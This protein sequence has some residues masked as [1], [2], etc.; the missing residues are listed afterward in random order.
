M[1]DAFS[2]AVVSIAE[3]S[4]PTV[5]N[6]RI[7]GGSGVLFSPDGLVLTNHHVVP[8]RDHLRVRLSDARV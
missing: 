5:V 7:K 6:I 1:L 2:R 3:R 8:R 4:R